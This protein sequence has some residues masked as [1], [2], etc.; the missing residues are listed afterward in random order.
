M[1]RDVVQWSKIRHRILVKGDSRRQVARETGISTNT[2]D[3]M[4]AH[5]HPQPY[6]PRSHRY[7]RLGPHMASEAHWRVA[8]IC[9]LQKSRKPSVPNSTPSPDEA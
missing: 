8:M 3:K 9:R 2:I 4:L 5:R 7:P 1:Y 6:G